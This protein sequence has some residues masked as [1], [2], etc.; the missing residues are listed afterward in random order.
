MWASSCFNVIIQSAFVMF[1]MLKKLVLMIYQSLSLMKL[2]LGTKK[3]A[4]GSCCQ[5]IEPGN[6]YICVLVKSNLQLFTWANDQ[7]HSERT[8]GKKYDL[9]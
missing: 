2:I 7:G 9:G 8:L 5:Y 4:S 3:N 1:S 6:V